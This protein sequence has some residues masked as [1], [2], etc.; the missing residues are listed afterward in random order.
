MEND[1]QRQTKANFSFGQKKKK[2]YSNIHL[3][4]RRGTSDIDA[5]LTN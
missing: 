3:M 4:L 1:N 5:K 2:F